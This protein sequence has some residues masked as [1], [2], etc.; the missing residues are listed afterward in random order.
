MIINIKNELLIK[1]K[2]DL[3]N[4]YNVKKKKKSLIYKRRSR[5]FPKYKGVQGIFFVWHGGG[6]HVQRRRYSFF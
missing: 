6:G 2:N 5:S 3:T 4:A 1:K